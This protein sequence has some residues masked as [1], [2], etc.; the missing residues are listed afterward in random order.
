M[1]PCRKHQ[2]VKKQDNDGLPHHKDAKTIL[3]PTEFNEA[4][5]YCLVFNFLVL[6]A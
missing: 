3:H 4:I 6:P 5:H 1:A 2:K